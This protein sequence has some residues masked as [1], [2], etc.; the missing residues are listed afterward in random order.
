MFDWPQPFLIAYVF[1]IGAVM[2]SF[3]N[4][5]IYR[6]PRRMSIVR[7][8]SGCPA[9]GAAIAWYDNIPIVSWLVL[10]ARCRRCNARISV[11]YPLVEAAAG[12]LAVLALARYGVS[13]AGAEAAIFSWASLALG[14]IDLEHQI[15]PDMMT[16]PAIGFGLLC[17]ALGGVTHL[18]FGGLEFPRAQQAPHGFIQTLRHELTSS[19]REQ[20]LADQVHC[21][22]RQHDQHCHDHDPGPTSREEDREPRGRRGGGFVALL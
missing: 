8:R 20:M 13:V 12:T 16:Y 14:L 5:V 7:P 15:L 21:R 1:A 4:V 2:G 22:E 3:L 17:S 10:R 9:C 18:L 6:V 11:R 19:N